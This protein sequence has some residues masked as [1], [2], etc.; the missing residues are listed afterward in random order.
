V[1]S[2]VTLED[3]T[4][5][6]TL[7]ATL[8]ATDSD[9]TAPNNKVRYQLIG[10]RKASQFFQVDPDSGVLRVR[11]DLRKETDTEYQVRKF[12]LNQNINRRVLREIL[13]GLRHLFLWNQVDSITTLSKLFFN[14]GLISKISIL[15]FYS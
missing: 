2:P 6:G 1:P 9:G 14:I 5:I 8:T 10:R 15:L 7:V 11:D 13:P 3:E 12:P 4:P